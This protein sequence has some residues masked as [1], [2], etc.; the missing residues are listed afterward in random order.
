MRIAALISLWCLSA[1]AQAASFDCAKATTPTE[2][3]ICS[4][5]RISDLDEYLGRY[6]SA[7]RAGLG[8][9]G[10]CLVPNQRD[11]LRKVRNACKDVACLES[12]YLARL[13][14]LDSLQP[15]AT[16]LKHEK[17]PAVQVLKW[18]VPPELDTVAA[19]PPKVH[20]PLVV[21]GTLV[22]DVVQGDGFVIQDD[23]GAKFVVLASMFIDKANG[24]AL[25]S[26]SHGEPMLFEVRGAK[27][28][29]GDGRA[30]FSQGACRFV[31]SAAP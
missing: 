2:K 20:Q 5:P 19:P 29:T 15:G 3:R 27:E 6:Y 1:L 13:A 30:H 4:S 11:W 10:A 25:E 8:R 21:K 26:L 9:G 12:A 24:V 17:L 31:Y 22:D 28:T 16:A 18:V 23:K 7:A 14:E